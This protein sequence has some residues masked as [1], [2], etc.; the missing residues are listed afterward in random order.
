M[1]REAPVKTASLVV[2]SILSVPLPAQELDAPR[3][4]AGINTV[5]IEEMTL[6]GG[7]RRD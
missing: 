3:P 1:R 7:P 2:A 5:F 4:M 6:D